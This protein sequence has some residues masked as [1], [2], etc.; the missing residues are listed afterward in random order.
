LHDASFVNNGNFNAGKSTVLFS[1]T[2]AINNAIIGGNSPVTFHH[3]AIGS[4][5]QLENDIAVNGSLYMQAG[6]IELNRHNIDLGRTGT[7]SG[8]N[9]HSFITGRN[10]GVVMATADMNAPDAWNPGNI[11]VSLTSSANFGVTTVTRGH[12]QQTNE[13]GQQSIYRYFDIKPSFNAPVDVRF[14]YLDEENELVVWENTNGKWRNNNTTAS[15]RFT[16]FKK[17]ALFQAYPN[18]ATDIIT[19]LIS[20]QN[21]SST[22]IL[23]QDQRGHTLEKKKITLGP[24]INTIQWNISKYAAGTYYLVVEND[25]PTNIKF[26]KH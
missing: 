18:P 8:E 16:M 2:G 10:G 26:I 15:G 14:N 20:S 5:V 19:T 24:G 25:K 7:I 11:G 22:V 4:A 12:I 6:N 3:V 1:S 13:L 17:S 23:L 9:I 21:Q